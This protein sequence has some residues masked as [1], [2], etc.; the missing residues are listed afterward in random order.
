M[1]REYFVLESG[2]AAKGYRVSWA[3]HEVAPNGTEITKFIINGTYES[4][5][6]SKKNVGILLTAWED[7]P[8]VKGTTVRLAYYNKFTFGD[9]YVVQDG[10]Q[11]ITPR[12]FASCKAEVIS[13]P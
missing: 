11:V 6:G 10:E 3:T 9:S 8:I 4:V 2:K 1:A 13:Q 7:L 12:Y 5:D